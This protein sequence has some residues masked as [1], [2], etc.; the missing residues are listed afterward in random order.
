MDEDPILYEIALHFGATLNLEDL[1]EVVLERVTSLLGLERSAIVL[2][3]ETALL[4]EA[5]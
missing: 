2:L 5:P 4:R 1:L 3:D